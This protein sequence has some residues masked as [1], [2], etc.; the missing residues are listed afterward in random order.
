MSAGGIEHMTSW[1]ARKYGRLVL[2]SGLSTFLMVNL[3]LHAGAG[4]HYYCS[5]ECLEDL[6]E[7][8]LPSLD[9]DAIFHIRNYWVDPP[10]PRGAYKPSFPVEKPPWGTMGNWGEAYKFINN[11]FSNYQ[12]PGTFLEIGAQDGEFMS[13]TLYME[14]ELGFRGL[15]VEPNPRDYKALRD[16][17]R[18]SASINACATP[19]GGH[20][21]DTLWLRHIPDNLPPLLRR[22]QAGNNRLYE[23]VS[24][25]DRDLGQTVEVQCFNA[26]ALAVAGLG[27]KRIDL[28]VISTHGGEMDILDSIPLS[29][30]F[31]VVVVV[32][33]LATSE[34]WDQLKRMAER[35]GLTQVFDK[36]NIHILLPSNEVKIV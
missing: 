14:Q 5:H 26:G 22:L 18:S 35:R 28:L 24:A 11:Y 12:R 4:L 7:G 16:N 15:L 2:A 20:R 36:Y 34:E 27:T 6:L 33:P 23:Y 9:R 13:L 25:E 3:T 30:H 29:V 10:A 32:V 8:P 17:R 19:R 31:K 1:A 21:K